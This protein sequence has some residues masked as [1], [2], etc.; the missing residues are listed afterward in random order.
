ML[1]GRTILLQVFCVLFVVASAFGQE[2]SDS[3]VITVTQKI[4]VAKLNTAVE[5]LDT[6]VKALNT[7]VGEL[8]TTVGELKTSVTKLEERTG[9]MLNL[10]YIILAGILGSPLVTILIYRRF[11]KEKESVGM[12]NPTVSDEKEDVGTG[13]PTLHELLK[14]LLVKLDAPSLE[15]VPSRRSSTGA[16]SGDERIDYLRPEYHST[17]KT[18]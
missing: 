18:V 9:I 10:L 16:P 12:G 11:N 2:E 17:G 6:T 3:H 15:E 5:N 4:D 7:T 8:K 14:E 1:N 13:D